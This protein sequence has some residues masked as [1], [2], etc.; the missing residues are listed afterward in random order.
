MA[1]RSEGAAQAL[2]TALFILAILA[3]IGSI[4]VGIAAAQESRLG[5][6]FL[7]DPQVKKQTNEGLAIVYSLGLIVASSVGLLP[8]FGL[9]RLLEG[10]AVLLRAAGG[11]SAA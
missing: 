4:A 8:L 3:I 2:S 5:T 11:D 6:D 9:S 1:Q 7:G 10:Q